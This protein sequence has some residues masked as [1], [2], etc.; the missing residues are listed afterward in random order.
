MHSAERKQRT[1][2]SQKFLYEGVRYQTVF[3]KLENF[4]EFLRNTPTIVNNIYK[5]RETSTRDGPTKVPL[6][7]DA[8]EE[9]PYCESIE[10]ITEQGYCA[11]CWVSSTAILLLVIAEYY[12]S[13]K[14]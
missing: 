3:E 7:Y 6:H 12:I 11:S 5:K 9:Y 4:V 8:A 14:F 10:T 2:E 1:D 13:W